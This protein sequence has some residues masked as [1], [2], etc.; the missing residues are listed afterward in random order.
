MADCRHAG[1]RYKQKPLA[2]NAGYS[3]ELKLPR[4]ADAQPVGIPDRKN[5]KE[6]ESE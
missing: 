4:L 5:R 1:C 2:A 3:A 6:R